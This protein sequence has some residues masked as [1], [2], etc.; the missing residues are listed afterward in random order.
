MKITVHNSEDL[1]LASKSVDV[2][3][4]SYG[5]LLKTRLKYNCK[6]WQRQTK[7]IITRM[8]SSRTRTARF[9]GH[10]Y[11]RG[12]AQ[13]LGVEGGVCRG[14]VSR[15]CLPGGSVQGVYTPAHCMLGYKR[16]PPPE[17]RM[18]DRCKNISFPQLRLRA[19]IM[20]SQ[21]ILISGGSRISQTGEPIFDFVV[22]T[23]YL[24]RFLPKTS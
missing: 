4:H 22:K 18:T 12:S 19:V 17:N 1:V 11:R 2:C 16:S 23:Y 20:D 24:A 3:L 9:K 8:H 6:T 5:V 10:L 14:C 15:G 13:R 21:W 7:I